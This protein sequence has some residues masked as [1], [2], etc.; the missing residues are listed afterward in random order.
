MRGQWGMLGGGGSMRGCWGYE[1]VVGCV[2]GWRVH[3]V[4]V[5][6]WCVYPGREHV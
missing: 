6:V 1:R 5:G 4:S 3:G 2:R